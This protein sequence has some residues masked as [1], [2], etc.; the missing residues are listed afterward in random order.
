MTG[1]EAAS[2][3]MQTVPA[4]SIALITTTD[5]SWQAM[6]FNLY[7]SIFPREVAWKASDSQIRR[8]VYSVP[9]LCPLC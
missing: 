1:C 4:A 3:I 7:P 8:R 6:R 5:A 9:P 2:G